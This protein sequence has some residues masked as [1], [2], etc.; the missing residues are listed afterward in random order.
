MT[1]QAEKRNFKE[2]SDLFGT[3]GLDI[4]KV[5]LEAK[6]AIF[7]MLRFKTVAK[8]ARNFPFGK[9]IHLFREETSLN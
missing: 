2:K 6:A 5:F 1:P 7:E 9:K 8:A 4:A 3:R